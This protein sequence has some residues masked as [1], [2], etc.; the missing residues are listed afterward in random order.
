MSRPV[1]TI[2]IPTYGRPQKLQ[3]CLV[4][5][6]KQTL[7]EPWE[8]VVVDDGS[9]Q[10]LA[11][12]GPAWAGRLDLRVIRQENA[13]PAAARNRGV[14]E[15]RGSLI[16]F[17]DD[18]CLPEPHW[19]ELLVRAARERPGALVGGSTVNGLG[20]ELFASTSQ[21][22]I[23]FV[24]SHFNADPDNAYFF[25]T[26]NLL[27][28]RER[29]LSVRGFDRSFPRAGA[30]DRDF[31]DRWRNAGWPLIWRPGARVEHRHSQTFRTFIDLHV[32]YGRGAYLYQVRRRQRRSGTMQDDLSFHTTL[33]RRLRD[34]LAVRQDSFLARLRLVAV[35]GLWQGANAAGFAIEAISAV[36]KRLLLLTRPLS[37]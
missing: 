23:D 11:A 18:D 22:I 20:G 9:P 28:P 7:A 15:A 24:Y 3:A 33:P 25:A 8:V 12:V 4:A 2:V 10:S 31:C 30:E 36:A 16:A 32:R 26:N 5:L 21:L 35:L 37:R 6:A 17:T 14:Q 29:F 1:V 19:L 13:G 27:C 34:Y